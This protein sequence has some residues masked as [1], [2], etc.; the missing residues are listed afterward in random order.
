MGKTATLLKKTLDALSYDGMAVKVRTAYNKK[1]FN[2]ETKQYGTGSQT[3]NAMSVYMNLV[4]P[5]YK[6]S[7]VSNIVTALRRH[8]NSLTAGDIGYRYLLRVLDDNGRSD[9]I[10]DMNSNAAVPGYGYQ[11]NL[12]ATALT[13]SWQAYD[14]ASNNHMML[15][16]LKE[17]FYSGLAGIRPEKNTVAFKRID[18]RPQPVGNINSASASY[19]SPYGMI[20]CDWKKK[21]DVF[22]LHVEIPANTTASIYLPAKAS[23]KISEGGKNLNTKNK[24]RILKNESGHALLTVGSGSYHFKVE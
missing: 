9:V 7:V 14:N 20:V 4:E 15:G 21:D 1:F 8:N 24:L 10:Y 18:I 3:S 16:H 5:Q 19:L 23:S 12:G 13:E 22:E 2:K 11:L 17:W 6:D